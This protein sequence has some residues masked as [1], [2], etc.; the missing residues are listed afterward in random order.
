MR[1]A[2]GIRAPNA[3]IARRTNPRAVF[4]LTLLPTVCACNATPRTTQTPRNLKALT[5]NPPNDLTAYS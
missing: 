2:S 3:M 1:F 5:T 4:S